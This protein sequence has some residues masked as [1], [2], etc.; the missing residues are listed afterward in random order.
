MKGQGQHPVQEGAADGRLGTQRR[1]LAQLPHFATR[2]RQHHLGQLRRDELRFQLHHVVAIV[3]AQFA[4]DRAQL[5]L[6]V[7]LALI[8]EQGTTHVVLDLPLESQ[9]LQLRRE[10]HRELLEE[11]VQR[12]RIE[13]P[14]AH[15]E[16]HVQVRR[17]QAGLLLMRLGAADQAHDLVGQPAMQGDVL[18]EYRDRTTRL[19]LRVVAQCGR[20]HRI[21]L[22]VRL[23]VRARHRVARD[24]GAGERLHQHA[25]GAVLQ[26]RDLQDAREH[27]HAIQVGAAWLL[28]VGTLL[29]D[30]E[31]Q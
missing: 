15:V 7:E 31:H 6:Q 14:L 26:P 18:L 17:H 30:E 3:V 23:Q 29:R 12:W 11:H 9:Q 10:R 25:R 5:L 19:T 1:H 27:A 16:L 28:G 8:L 13:Q 24:L 4:M 22:H 2:T 21:G 20:V